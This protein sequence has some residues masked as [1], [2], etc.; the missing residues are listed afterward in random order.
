MCKALRDE[1]EPTLHMVL[2]HI[3]LVCKHTQLEDLFCNLQGCRVMANT[4]E[5][6]FV[7]KAS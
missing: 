7:L 4:F 3:A 6:T 5:I 1:S 2:H